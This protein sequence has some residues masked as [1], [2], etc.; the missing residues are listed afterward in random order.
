M[1]DPKLFTV[2]SA[3]VVSSVAIA[4][5]AEAASM[6]GVD[7]DATNPNNKQALNLVAGDYKV[8]LLGIAD[9]G[10]YDAWS[11]RPFTTCPLVC[12]Q[13]RPITF[14]GWLQNSSIESSNITSISNAL[15]IG[16][17]NYL[18]TDSKVY[19]TAAA[20]T[21]AFTPVLFSLGANSNVNFAI[22]DDPYFDNRGGLSLKISRVRKR[23]PNRLLH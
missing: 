16:A 18:A 22:L 15:E 9:G 2:V 3:A 21:A 7:L 12:D 23:F 6:F 10:L 20:A 19:S 14:T 1:F 4:G 11:L 5:S 17:G 13:T 8:E